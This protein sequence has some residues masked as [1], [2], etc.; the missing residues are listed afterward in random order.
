MSN[1][2][3]SLEWRGTVK[4]GLTYEDIE[5]GLVSGD[6]H[7]LYK[8]QVNGRRLV[9]RDFVE[10][11]RPLLAP[12]PVRNLPPPQPGSDPLPRP[13]P[14]SA[15]PPPPPPGQGRDSFPAT[16]QLVRRWQGAEARLVLAGHHPLF[17]GLHSA[18]RR[19]CLHVS[20]SAHPFGQF[21]GQH[22]RHRNQIR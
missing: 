11:Q 22:K 14:L 15:V 12:P 16:S 1:T 7:T 5:T 17:H 21:I 6:L 8:I 4:S 10:Q 3:Y 18:R 20:H 2:T 19:V 13:D 9:L